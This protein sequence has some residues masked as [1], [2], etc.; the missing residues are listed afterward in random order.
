MRKRDISTFPDS[1]W[2]SLNVL[3]LDEV[4]PATIGAA[5]QCTAEATGALAAFRRRR[6]HTMARRLLL[7]ARHATAV[8][9]FFRSSIKSGVDPNRSTSPKTTATV[10][11]W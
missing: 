10:S 11:P 1:F 5:D 3:V 9:G 4:L 6:Y 8:L 7:T 2:H